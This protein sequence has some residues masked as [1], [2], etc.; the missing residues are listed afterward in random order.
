MYYSRMRK[1]LMH[2]FNKWGLSLWSIVECMIIV[3]YIHEC[4][5]TMLFTKSIY[6]IS[7]KN[8]ISFWFDYTYVL[9]LCM[10]Y[11]ALKPE[12]YLKHTF[13]LNLVFIKILNPHLEWEMALINFF[14][15]CMADIFIG[16]TRNFK[17][18]LITRIDYS[19]GSF[20]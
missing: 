19:V 14:I 2:C 17:I 6:H 5:G 18:P 13:K 12:I 16:F 15:H 10:I 1:I 7:E 9:N 3:L 4:M 8:K 20:H 11:F